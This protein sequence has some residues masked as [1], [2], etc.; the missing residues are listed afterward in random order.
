MIFSLILAAAITSCPVAEAVY[1]VRHQ[2]DVTAGFRNVPASQDW[3]SGL[4]LEVHVKPSGRSY[5]FLP[6]QGGTDQRTNMAWVREGSS[7]IQ[8]QDIRRD[9]QVIITDAEYNVLAEVPKAGGRAPS[10]FLMP[11]LGA[12]VWHS[13]TGLNRDNIARRFFDLVACRKVGAETP[14]PRIEFPPVP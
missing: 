11:D 5:W 3:P 10:H 6:W 7:P 8:Y 14:V 9:L 13:T 12:M 2:P 1:Q 4:A